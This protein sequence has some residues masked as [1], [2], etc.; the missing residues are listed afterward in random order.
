[1]ARL[2]ASEVAEVNANRLDTAEEFAKRWN[3]IVV[4][5]GVPSVIAG[6]KSTYLNPS[7]NHGMATAG[8]GDVLTGVIASLLSQGLDP[9]KSAALGVYIH[10]KA[11][12][13]GGQAGQ[14]GLRASDILKAIQEIVP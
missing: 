2:V 5:K 1:M 6:L 10:G 9:L 11:G 13:R 14:R 7:G 4:L 8:S 12:D 3:V